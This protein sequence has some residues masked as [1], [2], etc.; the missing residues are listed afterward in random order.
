MG[1]RMTVNKYVGDYRLVEDVDERGRIKTTTEYIGD[2]Y[3]YLADAADVRRARIAVCVAV[4]VAWAA[5]VA[6]LVPASSCMRHMQVSLPFAFGAV[7]LFMLSGVAF[8]IARRREPLERR[9]V[10]RIANRY[11]ASCAIFGLLVALAFVAAIV[12]DAVGGTFIPADAAFMACAA[13]DVL[14]ALLVY[15]KKDVFATR[16]QAR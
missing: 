16:A 4:A 1:W 13:T 14:M 15:S 10:D 12:S 3:F 8:Q 6:A 9:H 11:P 5:W 2:D 7:P